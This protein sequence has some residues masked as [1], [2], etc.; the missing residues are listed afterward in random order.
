MVILEDQTHK[1]LAR[2]LNQALENEL[3]EA[4]GHDPFERGSG[5]R[6][7]NGSKPLS[8]PRFFGRL[9]L[10]KPV[11]RGAT[12][13]ELNAAFGAKLRSAVE[14]TEAHFEAGLTFMRQPL[15]LWTTL[16]T[17]KAI[18]RFNRELRC[19]LSPA[20]TMMAESEVWKLVWAVSTE[21]ERRWAS[22]RVR[23]AAKEANRLN[24]AA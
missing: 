22:R 16:R 11:L 8:L 3:S 12:A 23:S 4:L 14:I 2:T 20:G 6:Y 15:A 24:A 13:Q 10:R 7:C 9:S 5:G 18:E 1:I 21:Q 17:S 19:R